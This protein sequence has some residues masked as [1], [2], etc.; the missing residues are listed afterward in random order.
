MRE[1]F[2]QPADGAFFGRYFLSITQG[3][4][5]QQPTGW[6]V[7]G[8]DGSLQFVTAAF[9]LDGSGLFDTYWVA[10]SGAF[11]GGIQFK[12]VS[13]GKYLTAPIDPQQPST[14]ITATGTA[15]EALRF[16]PIEGWPPAYYAAQLLA[17]WPGDPTGYPLWSIQSTPLMVW[18]IAPSQLGVQPFITMTPVAPGTLPVMTPSSPVA[19]TKLG[20][21]PALPYFAGKYVLSSLYDWVNDM[22]Q[23]GGW[24]CRDANGAAANAYQAFPVDGSGFFIA[25][26]GAPNSGCLQAGNATGQFLTLQLQT[27]VAIGAATIAS[28]P[29]ADF[30]TLGSFASLGVQ[31]PGDTATTRVVPG[32]QEMLAPGALHWWDGA[33][34][35]YVDMRTCVGSLTGAAAQ[36]GDANLTGALLTKMDLGAI[37]IGNKVNFTGAS[38]AQVK[39]RKGQD[40][41]SANFTGADLTGVDLSDVIL[42]SATLDGA[43]LTGCKIAGVDLSQA[44]CARTDF[45]NLDLTG[46]TLPLAAGA[47]GQ[48]VA[49]NGAIFVA[50]TVPVAALGADWRNLN[51]STTAFTPAAG[52]TAPAVDAGGVDLHETV[53]DGLT[54]ATVTK[55]TITTGA[56]FH[57]ADLTSASLH[58]TSLKSAD[59]SS[60]TLYAADLSNADLTSTVWSNAFLGTKQLLFTLSPYAPGDTATLNGG[61]VPPDLATAFASNGHPLQS[62]AVK[63][64]SNSSAWTI[65]DGSSVYSVVA[66]KNFFDVLISGQTSAQLSGAL[67]EN[68]DLTGGSFAGVH[69]GSVQLIGVGASAAG[70]DFEQADFSGANISSASQGYPDLSGAALYGVHFDGAFLF[71]ANLSN[72]YLSPSSDSMPAVLRNAM[73]AAATLTGAQLDGADMT[74]ALIGLSPQGAPT[75]FAGVPLFTLD[76]ATFTRILNDGADWGPTAPALLQE[77]FANNNVPLAAPVDW[78]GF[79]GQAQWSIV[80]V[81][82]NNL[83]SPP[84]PTASNLAWTTFMIMQGD[85]AIQGTGDLI[86]YGMWVWMFA[87]PPVGDPPSNLFIVA[88]TVW[89]QSDLAATTY[90]PNS[91]P[92]ETNVANKTPWEAAM[93]PAP[94]GQVKPASGSDGAAAS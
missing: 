75:A 47:M 90:C 68:A 78:Q 38:L 52:V 16:F 7:A 67:M 69:F 45:S 39:F 11:V 71:N 63:T 3:N 36:W 66:S 33:D 86:V 24:V 81:S 85:P 17:S 1:S 32:L 29:S 31:Y 42:K 19:G 62:P 23:T 59:F 51:L 60:A 25:Y 79:A 89:E 65:T 94:P 40:L 27:Y 46:T 64:R 50:A 34:L 80:S 9:P 5:D 43:K 28:A 92:W 93:M 15:A 91:R 70:V 57:F 77:A 72:A 13:T 76:A 22:D 2:D 83:D 87:P 10:A 30:T 37:N 53:L 14:S 44:S 26:S 8:A 73:L 21:G 54:F 58:G 56:S 12:S 48:G 4:S 88:P 49:D 55:D 82:D 74:G 20:S 18:R 35:S 41:G 61:A 6:I 84:A